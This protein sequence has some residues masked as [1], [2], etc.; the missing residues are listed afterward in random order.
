MSVSVDLMVNPPAPY[1]HVIAVAL[2]QPWKFPREFVPLFLNSSMI[3]FCPRAPVPERDRRMGRRR[4]RESILLFSFSPFAHP[5]DIFETIVGKAPMGV[6][7]L[8]RGGGGRSDASYN[9]EG[10]AG[11]SI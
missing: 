4:T 2:S 9:T 3:V 11:S 8:I 10:Q 5:R 1:V 6:I 7:G